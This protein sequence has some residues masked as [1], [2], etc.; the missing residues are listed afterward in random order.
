[1]SGESMKW[2]FGSPDPRHRARES[3]GGEFFN[4]ESIKN[5]AFALI[6]EGIQ[7]S[8][9]ARRRGSD[10]KLGTATVRIFVSGQTAALSAEEIRPFFKGA[11]AHLAAR[12]D[13]L[14]HAPKEGQTCP[15]MAF[16]DFGTSGLTGDYRKNEIAVG[17]AN[18]FYCFVRAEGITDK[19][20]GRGGSWGVGKLIFPRSSH[21]RAVL[22]CTRRADDQKVLTM[23]SMI[24]PNRI[25]GGKPFSPD[26]WLGVIEGDEDS[27]LVLPAEGEDVAER[28][29][30]LFRLQRANEPGLSLVIPWYDES[31]FDVE[32]LTEAVLHGWFY[33]ILAGELQVTIESPS[34]VKSINSSNIVQHVETLPEKDQQRVLLSNLRL[35]TAHL[36]GEEEPVVVATLGANGAP[37]WPEQ[38]IDASRLDEL[39]TRL[40]ADRPVVFRVPVVVRTTQGDVE[41]GTFDVCVLRDEGAGKNAVTAVRQG[42]LIPRAECA[43]G[44]KV[45]AL[46]VA[47]GGP[48]AQL[49]RQAEHPAHT[50]WNKDT[51][52]FKDT[53]A[54]GPSY[55]TVVKQAAQRLIS[56]M[57]DDDTTEDRRLLVDVFSVPVAPEV[58]D[59]AIET[60]KRRRKKSTVQEKS[61]PPED[62]PKKAVGYR[63]V[64]AEDGFTITRGDTEA[65]VPKW[66]LV[67]CGYGRRDGKAVERW[68]PADF[69]LHRPPIKVSP[70]CQGLEVMEQVRNV[71]KLRVID[72]EFKIT[73]NG[74]DVNRDLVVSVKSSFEEAADAD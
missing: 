4:D 60:R 36:S 23:G 41:E 22:F 64:R 32:K 25:V 67:R 10:G 50:H 15:F 27:G 21:S 40:R 51:G 45:R 9:D 12:P 54:N 63:V 52:N 53:Y 56:A 57:L 43:G 59:A 37:R 47:S 66:L 6:R 20:A 71:L 44:L 5:A 42:I 7:N 29:C 38:P 2:F 72:P 48:M 3:S 28:F 1:M 55:L 65:R 68:V 46:L 74:F 35:S 26:A 16:E 18:P 19:V 30:R 61:E 34:A 49:L 11:W 24:L 8:L 33:P 73:L 62:L 39:R 17:E 13:K 14:K 58:D 31:D 69:E 70:E